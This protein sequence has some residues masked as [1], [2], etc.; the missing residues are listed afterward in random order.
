MSTGMVRDP[1]VRR[2]VN[3]VLVPGFVG[4]QLPPWL[5]DELADGLGGVCWFAHN[6]PDRDTAR[7]L[8]DEIHEAGRRALVWC[9][10]EGGSVARLDLAAG[11]PWP[12]HAA[13][14][15][16][17]DVAVTR[18]VAEGIGASAHDAGIDVVLAPVVDVNSD[19]LNP[20]IG[21][22]S[23]GDSPDLVA[24]HGTAFVEGLQSTG[25]AG[26]AKHYPGH[27]ATRV[28]SHLGLPVVNADLDVLWPR[29]LAPF[30]AAAKAGVRC[31]LTAHVV[32]PAVDTEP[33][34]MS[35]TW[36]RLLREQIGFDGVVGTDALD[37]RAI[38]AGVGRG[39][40]AVAALRAGVDAVCIGN[41]EFPEK[42]DDV[43]VL[44]DVRSA[45]LRAVDDGRLSVERV[46]EA[47]GRL[48]DLSEWTRRRL[49]SLPPH[50][51]RIGLDA[52]R[53]SLQVD[54]DVRLTGDPLLLAHQAGSIAAGD[55]RFPI[56]RFLR[57]ARPRTTYRQV[58]GPAD[59]AAAM[60]AHPDLVP[61]VVTDGLAGTQ[62]VDAV[63]EVAPNAPVVHTGPAGTA[64]DVAAPLIRT[65]GGGAA[66]ARAAAERL[67]GA[68]CE[69][70]GER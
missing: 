27:G 69:A 40:G 54:G 28:D 11:S 15:R 42:Y 30:V 44:A 70:A 58:T 65:W 25:V 62:V 50:P 1:G 51:A 59:T 9:D 45:V 23:F 2:L 36:L 34:T 14:G 20:V 35:T 41:P 67:L 24:R 8:A 6:V 68:T 43:T 46:A 4:T 48:D 26:C 3:A 31:L 32:F 10:E 18:A 55:V 21:V 29:E 19:P 22:R 39:E 61:V 7:L 12:G 53:R 13:L 66:S 60:S 63:R 38:S 47:A 49:R 37:M 33:A 5:A 56:E 64:P 17:D 52:A 57:E 16:L